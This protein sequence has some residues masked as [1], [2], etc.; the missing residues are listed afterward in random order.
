MGPQYPNGT[1]DPG[2]NVSMAGPHGLLFNLEKDPTEH[3]NVAADPANEQVLVAV[4]A[5]LREL[6]PT[7]FSPVR[8]GGDPA[9]AARAAEARGGYWGPFIFP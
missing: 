7:V 1:A 3:R 6:Q 5:R 2:C 8:T 4:G 9:K